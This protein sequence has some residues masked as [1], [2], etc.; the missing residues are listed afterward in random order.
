MRKQIQLRA[1]ALPHRV[2]LNAGIDTKERAVGAEG[3]MGSL[4]LSSVT[5]GSVESGALGAWF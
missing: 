1:T 3:E 2:S 4:S 5:P